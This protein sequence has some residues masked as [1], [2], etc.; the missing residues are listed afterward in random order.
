MAVRE[1]RLYETYSSPAESQQGQL[2]EKPHEQDESR[3]LLSLS[4]KLQLF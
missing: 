4:K 3:A 2:I 1:N